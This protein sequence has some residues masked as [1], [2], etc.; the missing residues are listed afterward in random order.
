MPAIGR[1]LT[2]CWQTVDERDFCQFSLFCSHSTTRLSQETCFVHESDRSAERQLSLPSVGNV[3]TSSP[4]SAY[5]RNLFMSSDED[6]FCTRTAN[7]AEPKDFGTH[8]SEGLIG[9]RLVM[10]S[11]L[12][13]SEFCDR[14]GLGEVYLATDGDSS[15]ELAVKLLRTDRQHPSCYED[16]KRE[17][18]IM[19]RMNHP[20]IVAIHGTGETIDGRPF[21]AM[22]FLR[23]GNLRQSIAEYHRHHKTR[24][25]DAEKSFRDLLYRLISACKTVAYAHS[26]GVVHRDI[27]AENILLGRY[28]E[29]LVIDW[30]SATRV[31]RDERFKVQ[32]EETLQL[33]GIEDSS[34]TG[35]ITLRY[36]SPEQLHGSR[37]VG[38]ESDIYSLGATLYLMLTGTSPLDKVPD[39]QV[40]QRVLA[41]NIEPP[42]QIKAG[43]PR[44]LVAICGKAMAL[45]P[46]ERYGT[47]LELAED[48]E[49]FL[50]DESVSVCRDGFAVKILR[51]VRRNRT[52]SVALLAALLIGSGVIAMAAARQSVM[53]TKAKV[54]AQDRLKMAATM[55]AALG[56][57]EIERRI[58]IL[59]DE[60][61][62]TELI[63]ILENINGDPS[64]DA[65]LEK[66]LLFLYAMKDR[67]R[68]NGIVIESVLLMDAAGTQIARAPERESI[69]NNYSY[70][71]YFHGDG[72]DRDPESPEYLQ[73][74]PSISL[75]PV[76]SNAY[77]ST[78]DEEDGRFPVKCTIAVTVTNVDD[79][80]ERYAL[81]RLGASIFVNDFEIFHQLNELSVDALLVEMRDYSWGTGSAQGLLL[82]HLRDSDSEAVVQQGARRDTSEKELMD[83]MPRLSGRTVESMRQALANSDGAV[84]IPGFSDPFLGNQK[85]DAAI[86]RLQSSHRGAGD[87]NWAVLFIE[88]EESKLDAG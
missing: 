75:D 37:T 41:G 50:A 23:R 65:R 11:E 84:V 18:Q 83:A 7:S 10:Q 38:P 34:S 16:F 62:S 9:R 12:H 46:N 88:S 70:R 85:K 71:H 73:N 60:A 30:G 86:A 42:D 8:P 21:Y 19:G 22:P 47:A 33:H 61:R 76:L 59:E 79:A 28:G 52:A 63:N 14:G 29:T 49:R 25:V 78:N 45:E 82:D 43:I 40:R 69:G 3:A 31:R 58:R 87:T 24:T 74:P 15:R 39:Q 56:G 57:M 1:L 17:S 54:S 35:G 53:A 77:V 55:A 51:T 80:G 48:L 6:E 66:A 27:K 13:I 44:A 20:G 4:P 64:D 81:G 72:E 26:R 32:G 67:L 36:A 68:K 5:T 2:G